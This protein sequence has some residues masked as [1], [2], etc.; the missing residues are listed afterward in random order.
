MRKI[1]PF[2]NN[3]FQKKNSQWLG[4]SLPHIMLRER[5]FSLCTTCT[6]PK[7]TRK[8]WQQI[9]EKSTVHQRNVGH[10]VYKSNYDYGSRNTR[11]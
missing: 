9:T 3:K 5:S 2:R 10:M 8:Q 11:L 6:R 4:E 7:Y 1:K